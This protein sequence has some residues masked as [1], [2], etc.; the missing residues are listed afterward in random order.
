VRES[1][2]PFIKLHI[3]RGA[4]RS[5]AD[6]IKL[7][8]VLSVYSTLIIIVYMGNANE[9]FSIVYI[10][11]V[12]GSLVIWCGEV[13]GKNDRG[14]LLAECY[15]NTA[16]PVYMVLIRIFELQLKICIHCSLRNII[17]ITYIQRSGKTLFR[18]ISEKK[19]IGN[20]V[21]K[22]SLV[23]HIPYYIRS[24]AIYTGNRFTRPSYA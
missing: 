5:I 1:E 4:L 7:P 18:V 22:C 15:Y 11:N 16:P 10:H 23:F 9:F 6:A 24:L 2:R 21:E 3:N 17:T 20:K 14:K 19:I 12:S 13:R 8:L